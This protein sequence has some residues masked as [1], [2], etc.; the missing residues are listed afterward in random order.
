MSG[1]RY[2]AIELLL[3]CAEAKELGLGFSRGS[4]AGS[5]IGPKLAEASVDILTS[6]PPVAD[7]EV[8]HLE[9]LGLVVP[10]IAQDRL[11][12]LSAS[13]LKRF[14]IEYKQEQANPWGIPTTRFALESVWDRAASRW[15]TAR[16]RKSVW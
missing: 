2:E 10:L 5:A 9:I 12:D 15:P 4:K 14:F 13:V 8:S 11:S 1:Q 3:G 7:G 16:D 6:I